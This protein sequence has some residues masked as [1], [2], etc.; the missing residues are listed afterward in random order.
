MPL[1][2]TYIFCSNLPI[3]GQEGFA[4]LNLSVTHQF[5]SGVHWSSSSG[6]CISLVPKKN[7]GKPRNEQTLRLQCTNFSVFLTGTLGNIEARTRT[8][9]NSQEKIVKNQQ[10]SKLARVCPFLGF[11][12]L[13]NTEVRTRIPRN[14]QIRLDKWHTQTSKQQSLLQV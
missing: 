13:W 11:P 8:L 4:D 10:M 3:S 14:S 9:R 6:L 2:L 12:Q 1:S 7:C 5:Q